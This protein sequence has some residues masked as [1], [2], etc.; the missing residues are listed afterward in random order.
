[1]ASVYCPTFLHFT[2]SSG[3]RYCKITATPDYPGPYSMKMMI[4]CLIKQILSPS[5]YCCVCIFDISVNHLA[6]SSPAGEW[7]QGNELLIMIIVFTQVN[8]H[9]NVYQ[10]MFYVSVTLGLPLVM[11]SI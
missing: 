4:L 7:L 11:A 6:E 9:S 10:E 3:K 1:M 5:V 8:S 2:I